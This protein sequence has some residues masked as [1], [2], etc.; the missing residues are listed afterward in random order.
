MPST[1]TAMFDSRAEAE[2]AK[3]QLSSARVNADDVQIHD[4]SSNGFQESG[5][6]S[7]QDLG[8]WGSIKNAF[9]PDEDRHTYEEGVRRGGALLTADVDDDR[10]DEVLRILEDANCVDI[11]ER[12][13]EWR[14]SGW[15]YTPPAANQSAFSQFDRQQ[16]TGTG[17]AN[18]EQTIPVIEESLQVGKREVERGGVRVRSYVTETPVHEQIRLREEHV[19][20]ERRPV[21]QPLTSADADAFRERT[22]EMTATSEEAVVGKSAR[23]VEEVVVSKTSG[24]HVEDVSDTVRHTEVEVDRDLD[25]TPGSAPRDPNRQY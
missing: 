15:D 6:S 9:L 1:I 11:D 18:T 5:Y 13:S 4:R 10:V 22:V 21:N 3:Q 14:S 25:R 23:V 2:T 16:P 17:M 8:F 12:A 19:N 24:E 20:V 7:Q